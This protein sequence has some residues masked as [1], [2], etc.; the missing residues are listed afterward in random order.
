MIL[1][2][3]VKEPKQKYAQEYH[4]C[5][6]EIIQNIMVLRKLLFFLSL[7]L[8]PTLSFF[9]CQKGRLDQISSTNT[10][11]TESVAMGIKTP[12]YPPFLAFRK[13]FQSPR[14][15]LSFKEQT[16]AVTNNTSE[17]MQKQR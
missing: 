3:E 10:F 6:V 8:Y 17:V 1:Q 13:R 7:S 2:Y 5:K 11:E 12:P 15:S 14:S 9:F 16:E 4:I